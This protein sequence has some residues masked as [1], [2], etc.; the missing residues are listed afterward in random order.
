LFA[1]DVKHMSLEKSFTPLRLPE[2]RLLRARGSLDKGGIE[3]GR[4]VI[5]PFP[6]AAE[7]QR[8]R[9][10]HDSVVTIYG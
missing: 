9:Q 4:A 5:K 10:H 1:V 7:A 2:Q 3:V 8:S 6:M